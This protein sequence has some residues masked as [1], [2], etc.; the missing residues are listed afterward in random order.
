MFDI[1]N[2]KSFE[3]LGN[4]KEEFLKQAGPRNPDSFPFVVLGNK[5]DR[6]LERKITT[7]KAMNWCKTSGD[8]PYFETSAKD[9]TNVDEAFEIAAKL[10]LKN[11]SMAG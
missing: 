10:A 2:P 6:D 7:V 5:A 4:W 11:Q 3:M 1:T 8:M 9:Q